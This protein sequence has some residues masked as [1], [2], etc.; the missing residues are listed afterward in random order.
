MKRLIN[1]IKLFFVGLFYGLKSA[2]VTMLHQDDNDGDESKID[3]QMK[4][5]NVM[6]DFLNEQETQRVFSLSLTSIPLICSSMTKG[7]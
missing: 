3:Q 7:N 2:D 5:D 1:K 6:S 4:I